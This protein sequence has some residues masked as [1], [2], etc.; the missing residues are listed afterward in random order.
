MKLVH[1]QIL[2]A[3]LPHVVLK[4]DVGNQVPTMVTVLDSN[5][6]P[7]FAGRGTF[8]LHDMKAPGHLGEATRVVSA[9]EPAEEVLFE[10]VEPNIV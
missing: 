9:A 1:E 3:L 5:S 2:A 8:T 7:T 10:T 6:V 4:S